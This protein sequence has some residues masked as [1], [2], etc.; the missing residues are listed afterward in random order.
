MRDIHKV[1]FVAGKAWHHKNMWVGILPQIPTPM[2]SKTHS[3][4][5]RINPASPNHRAIL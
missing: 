2:D 4:F 1:A 3:A 5:A